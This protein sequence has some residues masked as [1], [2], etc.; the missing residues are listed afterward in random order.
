MDKCKFCKSEN[1]AVHTRWE[2]RTRTRRIAI[3]GEYCAD[4]GVDQ[5]VPLNSLHV[6]GLAYDFILKNSAGHSEIGR[7]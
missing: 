5:A 3:Q 7:G 6:Y 4:C 2:T 1:L